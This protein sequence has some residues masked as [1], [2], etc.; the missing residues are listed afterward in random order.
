M[1]F[2][3]ETISTP[4]WLSDAFHS[5]CIQEFIETSVVGSNSNCPSCGMAL[6]VDLSNT[7]ESTV[8]NTYNS[9]V[10]CVAGKTKVCRRYRA[11]LLL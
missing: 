3:G 6:T 4:G 7:G 5:L 2:Q 10:V 11:F 8:H 9:T 1:Q